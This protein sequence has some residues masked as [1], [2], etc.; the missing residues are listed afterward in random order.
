MAGNNK[1][2]KRGIV[3]YIDGKEVNN[4]AK[5]IQAEMRKVKKEIDGCAIGSK[6][7]IAATKRYRE[8]KSILD[9]HKKNLGQVTQATDQ[10]KRA[11]QEYANSV[12]QMLGLNGRF[13][14]S[15]SALSSGGNIFQNLATGAS[16]FVKTLL[17]LLANP[18]FLAM[19]GLSGAA[20]AFKFWYDYNKGIAEATRLTKEFLGL[21]GNDL[22]AVRSEIQAIADVYGKD[23]KSI[24]Q[25]IDTLTS[26]YGITAAEALDIVKDGFIA[27]ADANG[28]FLNQLG[29]YSGAFHDIGIQADE[30]TALISQTR[31]GIFSEQGMQAIQMAGKRIREMGTEVQNALQTLNINPEEITKGL[32]EGSISTFDVIRRISEEMKK[33]NPQS[34]EVGEVLKDVFGKQGSAAG[35]QLVTAFAD[36]STSIEE[37]KE[38]TGEYGKAM[39]EYVDAQTELNAT[40]AALFDV[41]QKGFDGMVM[42]LK[43]ITTKWLTDMLRGLVDIA[44]WFIKIYNNSTILRASLALVQRTFGALWDVVSLFGSN[45]ISV[46][47]SI[48]QV[49]GGLI[50]SMANLLDFD[51]EGAKDALLNM[52]SNVGSTWR[53]QMKSN[54]QVFADSFADDAEAIQKV[55]NGKI[56]PITIPVKV[57]QKSG[58]ATTGG[59]GTGV[60]TTITG[61]KGGGA[62]NS[63][64]TGENAESLRIKAETA[65]IEAEIKKRENILKQEYASGIK[66]RQQYS[67]EMQAIEIDRIKQLLNIAGLESEKVAEL[68]NKLVDFAVKA[69]EQM[70]SID[71]SSSF[72]NDEGE[73]L[74]NEY[75]KNLDRLNQKNEEQIA[76]LQDNLTLRNITQEDFNQ[77]KQEL[78][79]KFTLE[80]EK[81]WDEYVQKLLNSQ[82]DLIGNTDD[83]LEELTA[84]TEKNL[85]LFNETLRPLAES[86]GQSLVDSVKDAL[87]DGR[88]P[89]KAA[90]KAILKDVVN[91]IQKMMIAAT[92]QRTIANVGTLGIVGIAKAAG[93]IAL[94]SAAGAGLNALIDSFADGGYTRKGS[95]YTPAGIVHAGEFVAT[96]EAV[97]NPAVKPVLDAI[98]MAQRNGTIANLTT[99]DIASIRGNNTSIGATDSSDKTNALISQ[100]IKVMQ[101]V[102]ERFDEPIIAETYATGKHGT[103]EA[104]ETVNRMKRNSSR[105]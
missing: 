22:V 5:S 76:I 19:A 79:T 58:T 98:D 86:I 66:N 28:T 35:Y 13:A 100:C 12:T 102:K 72:D 88:D 39:E 82:S 6:E 50:D 80:Q 84:I 59:V 89:I 93:E 53:N 27:G 48:G 92:A 43:T 71:F 81:L 40:T 73:Q 51:F 83:N 8:L 60:G 67:D 36:V 99:N 56:K 55:I 74:Y 85:K 91:A 64:F 52:F 57:E 47:K 49:L 34:K 104:T 10:A 37:C 7:Y 16:A 15:L 2:V 94:I 95:K 32:E 20:T 30:L 23:Y 105:N 1:D 29:Q 62:S 61:G 77:K 87:E 65:A 63:K 17:G 38:Q 75:E 45:A 9:E 4:S 44:N 14:S 97:N 69:R 33:L 46:F 96:Q 21:Q 70:E 41:T 78:D 31:S 103:I 11:G 3:L 26:Q 68:Q 25:S 101:Q 18:A 54:R 24:L 90:L 42:S